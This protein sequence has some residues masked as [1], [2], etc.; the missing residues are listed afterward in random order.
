[1]TLVAW[2]RAAVAPALLL[3]LA[4]QAWGQAPAGSAVSSPET[5]T[6]LWDL[7]MSEEGS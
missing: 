1:M 7:Q 6:W 5:L 3:A 2:N 4:P